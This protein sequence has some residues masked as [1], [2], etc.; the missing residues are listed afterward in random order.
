MG[1]S[2][3]ADRDAVLKPK[4]SRS[5]TLFQEIL[6]KIMTPSLLTA[7]KLTDDIHYNLVMNN[8]NTCKAISEY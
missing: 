3:K 5:S 7:Q 6:M 4:T 2:T 1:D 8:E